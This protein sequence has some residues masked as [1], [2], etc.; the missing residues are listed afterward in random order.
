MELEHFARQAR[1]GI[2]RQKP[3]P[4]R[5]TRYSSHSCWQGKIWRWWQFPLGPKKDS[6][7]RRQQ[8]LRPPGSDADADDVIGT[9]NDMWDV[10]GCA[11][12]WRLQWQHRWLSPTSAAGYIAVLS[13]STFSYSWEQLPTSM[14]SLFL[15]RGFADKIDLCLHNN[16][17]CSLLL[18]QKRWLPMSL[19]LVINI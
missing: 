1:R 2:S 13:P 7:L 14:G 19:T 10:C 12:S 9:T 5:D 17:H 6:A 11:F 3:T 18:K 4:S 16:Q 8:Y 15:T